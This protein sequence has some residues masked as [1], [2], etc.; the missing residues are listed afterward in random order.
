MSFPQTRHTLIQRIASAGDDR[1]WGE[2]LNDYWGPICRFARRSGILTFDD[3][4]D[5]AAQTF[6]V[7]VRNRLLSEWVVRRSAKLRTLL[8]TV[9]R[10][11]LSNRARVQG[12]RARLLRDHGGRLDDRGALPLVTSLDAPA[13]QVDA[14]HAAWVE[15]LLQQAVAALL[16]HYHQ[17]GKGDFFRV[18]YGRLCDAMTMAEIA[19]ALALTT[20]QA[21]N[22]FKHAKKCLARRLEDLVRDYVQRYGNPK[23][24]E[25]EFAAEWGRLG[26]YLIKHGGLEEAVRRAYEGLPPASQRQ[27][28]ASSINAA[29]AR[30]SEWLGRSDPACG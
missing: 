6:E 11:V 30:M 19:Q 25:G 4:E 13:E 27:P 24:V 26:E 8:C 23:D 15:E 21:E 14:F 16:S 17:E 1:D 20:T 28:G 18:L 29:L 9:V 2:F 7:L 3:A 5:V 10:N 12:G 22:A